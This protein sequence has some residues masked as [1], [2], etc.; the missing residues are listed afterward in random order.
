MISASTSVPH[1]SGFGRVVLTAVF[2]AAQMML[3]IHTHAAAPSSAA[4]GKRLRPSV[5]IVVDVGDCRL[6]TFASHSRPVPP[7]GAVPIFLGD[8]VLLAPR[9]KTPGIRV[10]KRRERPARA[11]PSALLARA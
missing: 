6:C 5:G 8:S 3:S 9:S 2:V 10:E 7:T 1:R 4:P 11:P